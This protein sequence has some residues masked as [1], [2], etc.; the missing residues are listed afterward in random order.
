MHRCPN[1]AC[2]SRGLETLINWVQGRGGHRRRR[3]AVVRRLW[4]EGPRPLDARPLPADEGAA[5]RARRLRR[6]LARGTRSRRSGRRRSAC[7]SRASCFGLNIPKV[8]WVTGAEPRA[9]LRRRRPARWPR[10]RRRSRR[11]R[12]SAPTAPR[13]SPSG[14]PTR[15]TARSSRSSATLGLRFEAGEEDR[16]VEGPLTGQTYVV[17]GHARGLHAR[18]GEG[19][20]RGEGREGDRLGLEEDDRPRRRRGARRSKVAKA[21]KAGVPMLDE[22]ELRGAAGRLASPAR[23]SRSGPAPSGPTRARPGGRSGRRRTRSGGARSP[24]GPRRR[25]SCPSSRR[26]SRGRACARMPGARASRSRPATGERA[27]RTAVQPGSSQAASSVAASA[28]AVVP[29]ERARGPSRRRSARPASGTPAAARSRRDDARA[30]GRRALD[31]VDGAELLQE[32]LRGVVVALVVHEAQDRRER[33]RVDRRRAGR[34]PGARAAFATP[35]ATATP[36]FASAARNATPA[37]SAGSGDVPRRRRRGRRR[38]PTAAAT[39]RCST[40]AA[41]P[42]RCGARRR[43]SRRR[44]RGR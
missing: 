27:R 28:P 33:S 21:Q 16:P 36:A 10:R 6:D 32:Q 7:R 38:A 3:G 29:V 34:S 14:S 19:G 30:R 42:A 23:T 26:R 39:P 37:E 44:A 15:R 12:A 20:A 4:D 5:A 22:A 18:G 2:P 1:R 35:P 13:R 43:R 8:G 41:S 9:A 11:S 40:R 24:R 17:T 25:S 31:A